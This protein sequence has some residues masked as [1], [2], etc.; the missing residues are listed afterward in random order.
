MKIS[1]IMLVII[2][3]GWPEEKSLKNRSFF[4]CSGHSRGAFPA[5][6]KA[7]GFTFRQSMPTDP[8]R[9][10][11]Q[12]ASVQETHLCKDVNNKRISIQSI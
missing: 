7:E 11:E 2:P 4:T 10:Q 6:R 5:A 3:T 1:K 12:G 9:R 8:C